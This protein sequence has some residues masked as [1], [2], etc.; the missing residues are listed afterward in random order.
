MRQ[1]GLDVTEVVRGTARRVHQL[2]EC[3][4]EARGIPETR[5][6]ARWERHGVA[7]DGVAWTAYRPVGK[8]RRKFRKR[9]AETELC[10][11]LESKARKT[12]DTAAI[13]P[14]GGAAKGREIVILFDEA[15][16]LVDTWLEDLRMLLPAD[17]DA[18]ARATLILV[19]RPELCVFHAIRTAIPPQSELRAR[20]RISVHDAGDTGRDTGRVVDDLSPVD[21]QWRP[22][23]S[24]PMNHA[25]PALR[26]MT[27]A[28]PTPGVGLEAKCGT[29]RLPR[30]MLPTGATFASVMGLTGH[31]QAPPRETH[32]ASADF[33]RPW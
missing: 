13:R 2:G 15:H 24:A 4:A 32:A 8:V 21:C 12:R 11:L 16:R 23:S 22:S 33:L 3:W 7:G 31:A 20:R 28:Q 29:G 6:Q 26:T 10:R 5:F 25:I 30:P 14:P 9:Q 1:T 17:M 19:G 18:D 27:P